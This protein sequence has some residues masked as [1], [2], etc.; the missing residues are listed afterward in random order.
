VWSR[1]SQ[2]AAQ[3]GHVSNG[4]MSAYNRHTA[5]GRLSWLAIAALHH[6][7]DAAMYQDYTTPITHWWA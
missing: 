3:P 5:H 6:V 2:D 7:Q 1:C 4:H